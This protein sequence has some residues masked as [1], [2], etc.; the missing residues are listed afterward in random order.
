[1]KKIIICIVLIGC[2]AGI[3]LGSNALLENKYWSGDNEICNLD[4]AKYENDLL[5]AKEE[6]L[7]INRYFETNFPLHQSELND[8]QAATIQQYKDY[9]ITYYLDTYGVDVSER[10]MSV[11]CFLL[12]FTFLNDYTGSYYAGY[13]NRDLH[14]L[15]VSEEMM[16]T[17]D[18]HNS[19]KTIIH[20]LVHASG[21]CDDDNS[22][23]ITEGFTEAVTDR[24]MTYHG[25]SYIEL[26]PYY[27]YW[28]IA[29]QLLEI[30][31]QIIV[32]YITDPN[33]SIIDHLDQMAGMEIGTALEDV[34]MMYARNMNP[35]AMEFYMQ[36]YVG[37]ILKKHSGDARNIAENYPIDISFFGIR[38]LMATK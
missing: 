36:Y 17:L 28:C 30:D 16:S 7:D 33:F 38:S 35:N 32:S 14:I 8:A 1:M 3:I 13:Y 27:S 31:E 23:F 20:E 19:Q 34:C 26:G 10:I 21:I 18:E 6:N 37:D 2:L 9:V 22:E 12:D 29:N 4:V 24:I 15:L 11:E 5:A 25:L